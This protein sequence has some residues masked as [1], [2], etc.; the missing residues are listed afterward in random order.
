[1][2]LKRLVYEGLWQLS[3]RVWRS[4][5]R[6]MVSQRSLGAV[7]NIAVRS[8]AKSARDEDLLAA[9]AKVRDAL[10]LLGSTDPRRLTRLQRDIDAMSIV[11]YLRPQ[12]G[13]LY[14]VGSRT[15]YLALRPLQSES[16][17][18]VALFMVHEAT[19]ARLDRLHL[20]RCRA[21]TIR[22]ERRALLEEL[23]FAERL[24]RT[25]FP[26]VDAFIAKHRSTE[27]TT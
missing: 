24:P 7:W 9:V 2:K 21:A 23:S 17:A 11:D 20:P 18:Q 1:M 22:S 27:A 13:A 8:S 19:H 16:P 15:C 26:E 6:R 25:V 12:I 10:E 3:A 4:S 14:A 5:E